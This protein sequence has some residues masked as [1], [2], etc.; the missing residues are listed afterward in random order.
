VEKV[1]YV[2]ERFNKLKIDTLESKINEKFKFVKFRMFETQINGGESECC[3]AL[4]NGVPF[5]DANTASKINGGL[6]IINTLCEHYQVTA[7][8]FI[9][10][11]ESIIQV[12]DIQSQ[13]INLI[14]SENDK[15][16]RVA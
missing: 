3:D 6:D 13:L 8:I 4:I 11:R 12:I 14:V 15:K 16:L 5:S 9:D 7:P 10:N 2:I 1:Q